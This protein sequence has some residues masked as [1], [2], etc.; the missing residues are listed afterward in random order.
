MFESLKNFTVEQLVIIFTT[1]LYT[2][3]ILG[4]ILLSNFQSR[5]YYTFKDTVTNLYL[6]ILNAGLDLLTRGITWGILAWFFQFR[7]FEIENVYLYW[8]VLFLAEDLFIIG[9]TIG[10]ITVDFFGLL[11]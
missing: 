1:P 6:M 5:G 8:F 11:T 9:F 3:L 10:T 4:E 7:L 2:V